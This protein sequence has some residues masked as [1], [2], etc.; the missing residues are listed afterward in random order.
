[1][2][3]RSAAARRRSRAAERLGA[4]DRASAAGLAAVAR[5]GLDVLVRREDLPRSPIGVAHPDLVLARVATGRVHL[6]ERGQAG[7]DEPLLRGQD[8]PGRRNLNAGVVER[9]EAGR[10]LALVEREVDRRL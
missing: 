1:S 6:V 3:D 5:L 9:A 10:A 8:V 2:G 7:R 4:L